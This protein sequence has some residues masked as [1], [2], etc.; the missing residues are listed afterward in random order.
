M[1]NRRRA[2]VGLRLAL[3][4]EALAGCGIDFS[5]EPEQEVPS[6]IAA[7]PKGPIFDLAQSREEPTVAIDEGNGIITEYYYST[8]AGGYANTYASVFDPQTEMTDS[9]FLGQMFCEEGELRMYIPFDMSAVTFGG[10]DQVEFDQLS[11]ATCADGTFSEADLSVWIAPPNV[12]TQ[13]DID[14]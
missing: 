10:F 14:A 13:G 9:L 6:F 5:T 8:D 11:A 3:S 12:D 4:I 2:A 1:K 7:N